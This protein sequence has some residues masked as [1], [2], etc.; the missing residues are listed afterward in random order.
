MA[1]VLDSEFE[2]QSRFYIHIWTNTQ[3]KR[4]EPSF[5]SPLISLLLFYKD[6]FGIK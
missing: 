3:E 5:A 1:K 6:I 2:L 4:T